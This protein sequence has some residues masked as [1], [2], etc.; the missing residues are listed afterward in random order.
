MSII[1]KLQN[2]TKAIDDD[3]ELCIIEDMP[4]IEVSHISGDTKQFPNAIG[5][6][7]EYE[8]SLTIE[9]E[10]RLVLAIDGEMYRFYFSDINSIKEIQND[11]K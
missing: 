8:E 6:L 4:K 5:Y 7:V 9:N 1:N 10:G 11:N 3:G 2:I